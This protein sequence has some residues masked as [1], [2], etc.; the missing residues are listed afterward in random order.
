MV[1]IDD[2]SD[3]PAPGTAATPAMIMV[4]CNS[5][6]ASLVVPPPA[7]LGRTIT[8]AGASHEI[9]DER[10][11]RDHA[12]VS[13]DRGT[14]TIRDLDSRNGTYVNGERVHGEVKRR[15]DVV[16]RIGH[17]ILVLVADGRGHPR[18]SDATD[19]N[20]SVVGPELARVHDQLQ[21]LAHDGAGLALVQGGVGSGK[22]LA[23]RVYH[24]ASPRS[25]PFITVGC[26]AIHGVAERLLFGGKKGVVETI[27]HL[28]MARGGTLYLSDIA[29]LD[30]TAQASL[31]RLLAARDAGAPIDTNIVCSGP[32][33]RLAVSDGRLR[34]DLYE[35]LSK[36]S[37]TVPPL[38][39]RRVDL[40]R[41]MQ[42][43]AAELGRERGR[44]LML[45]PRLME[46]CLLRPWPHNVR[47]LRAAIR[48]AGS[49]A[50]ADDREMIRPEDL[51][52]SAGLPPG[53]NSAETAVERK[54]GPSVPDLGPASLAQAMERANGSLAVAARA[55]N[56]H[57]TQ[58][59]KLLEE[60]AIP[61]EG[62]AHDD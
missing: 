16:L 8:A 19:A 20:G 28:Q 43:E 50:L 32:D 38:R 9:A 26:A 11:S 30:P 22:Q 4:A 18:I 10:M 41:L 34:P 56:M 52:D 14:W 12:K 1:V 59:A 36:L 3:V 24:A 47:E 31:A 51:L 7:E 39:A 17:T 42:L 27:G 15:G 37:V 40:A 46:T 45:H 60:A 57:R 54:S 58:L 33:L 29:E 53:A 49:R 21:R 13:W 5:A 61:Y 35:R 23:A 48:H 55:L 62:L 6:P 44:A 25:G 2:A